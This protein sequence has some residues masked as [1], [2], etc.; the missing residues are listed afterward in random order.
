[1]TTICTG[2]GRAYVYSGGAIKGTSPSVVDNTPLTTIK[3][4]A[5]QVP[6]ANAQTA[7]HQVENFGHA[8]YPIGDVGQCQQGAGFIPV[9]PGSLC[10]LVDRTNSPDGIPDYI[11]SAHRAFTPIWNPDP[12]NFEEGAS[13]LFDG[14][15][16]SV[17]Q[18]YTDP[19]P[20]PDSLFGFTTGEQFPVGDVGESAL[21]DVILASW[22]DSGSKTQAG[23]GWVFSGNVASNQPNFAR[24]DDPQPKTMARFANP[25]EGVGKLVGGSA[26]GNQVLVGDFSN[27]PTTGMADTNT[28]VNF[29]D[30]QNNQSLQTIQDP[31]S[32]AADGFGMHVIPLG[33]LNGTGFLSFAATAPRWASSGASPVLGQG[34]IY[35]FTP[36][37]NAVVPT[38]PGPPAG[39]AGP[40]GSTGPAGPS[41]SSGSGSTVVTIS[42]RTLDLDASK[43][44]VK[45]GGSVTL[46]GVLE[47][48]ANP[49]VC[50]ASQS[51]LL[52]A[53]APSGSVF[54]TFATVKTTASGAFKSATKLRSTEFF[55]ARIGQTSA[56][57]GAQSD[58]VT[59]QVS[60]RK[61]THHKRASIRKVGRQWIALLTAFTP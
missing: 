53:R 55:R 40:A 8:Q 18:V 23:V 37:P 17:L 52:Q 59:V 35:I 50:Q 39:P 45:S 9:T 36:N 58:R 26:V 28:T 29:M 32:Q 12:A 48:F 41:G 54:K 21:P 31:D 1:V 44:T 38:P 19:Q 49:T 60:K 47:A 7:G 13:F 34:R 11:I 61:T 33:D 10:P 25:V 46:R 42:G 16:G 22:N 2:A 56:C 20:M 5:A 14:K 4:P 57:A 3:D 30:P 24:I 15:T 27:V 43:S 51:V 6:F